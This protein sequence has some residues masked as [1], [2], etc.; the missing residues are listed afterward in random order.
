MLNL[1]YIE[2]VKKE[3]VCEHCGQVINKLDECYI[4][5]I[6]GGYYCTD[7]ITICDDCETFILQDNAEYLENYNRTV[8]HDCLVYNYCLCDDCGEYVDADECQQIG[9]RHVCNNCLSDNYVECYECGDWV[10]LDDAIYFDDEYYCS[11]CAPSEL[12]DYNHTRSNLTFRLGE[13]E[14]EKNQTRFFGIELETD[15]I[16]DKYSDYELE[17]LAIDVKGYFD[18]NYIH[19]KRDGSLS[20]GVEFVTEPSTWKYLESQAE[21]IK[22]ALNCIYNY[23]MRSHDTTTCGLHC[24]VN[25]QSFTDWEKSTAFMILWLD[26]NWDDMVKFSRRN[27]DSLEQWAKKNDIPDYIK[28]EN[29]TDVLTLSNGDRYNAINITNRDTIEFRLFRGTLNYKTLSA[30]IEFVKLFCEWAESA[31]LEQAL[32]YSIFD[33]TKNASENLKKYIMKRGIN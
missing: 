5:I 21:N 17:E 26:K 6:H 25:K 27:Y 8:C 15:D 13:G 23:D 3:V 4:D 22:L 2:E 18:E 30:T 29:I 28:T 33:I 31:T 16:N 19:A 20:N 1:D 12:E 7:C 14:Q 10:R 32:N 11:D 9:Y 24:H